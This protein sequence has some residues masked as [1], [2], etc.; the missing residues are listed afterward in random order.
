MWSDISD[1]DHKKLGTYYQRLENHVSPKANPVFARFQFHS[2]V[3][4]SSETAE[5]FIMALRILAQ[6]CDFKDPEEM[7]RDRIVFGMNSLKVREKLI[8][9]RAKLT[10]E[11]EKRDQRR[12]SPYKLTLR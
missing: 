2:R 8:S 9:K 12:R 5:K 7:I 1:D 11:K 6:H 4:E 10:L 3:Q